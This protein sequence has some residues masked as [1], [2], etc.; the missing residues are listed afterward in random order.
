[1]TVAATPPDAERSEP[2]PAA[3]AFPGEVAEPRR[4]DPGRATPEPAEPPA[5]QQRRGFVV[6]LAGS[7][8]VHLLPAL[9]LLQ[10]GSAP[11]ETARPIP[12][13]LVFEPPPAAPPPPQKAP[14]P[15]R[16]ASDDFGEVTA[17]PAEPAAK[18]EP[19]GD[20][21]EE[22]VIA[23]V[24]PPSSRVPPHELVS[25]LPKPAPPAEPAAP[26]EE[27]APAPLATPQAKRAVV[28]KRAPTQHPASRVASLPG[29]AATRD[30]YLAYC[31]MLIM[32]Y[33]DLVPISLVGGRRGVTTL[34][35]LVYGDGTIGRI[36]V[37]QSSG[38]PDIDARVERMVAAVG[39]FP[40]LPQWIQRPN[41]LLQYNFPFPTGLLQN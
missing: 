26:P 18:P 14:P 30:E 11:A 32:R 2:A 25:A 20:R 12:V 28:T 38:Y 16:L 31:K 13:N 34:N 37:A 5:G 8:G 9:L 1:M 15:G 19:A 21:L 29:P 7:L 33:R 35:I 22:T 40:P 4:L 3:M 41:L 36:A 10:L 24:L 17:K 39:R 6:G 23:A 27:P